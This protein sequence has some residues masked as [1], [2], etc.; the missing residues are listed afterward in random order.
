[1]T[2]NHVLGLKAVLP[3]A[4]LVTLG[5]RSLEPRRARP[6]RRLSSARKGC[7]ASRSRSRCGCCRGRR[8]TAPC[9][10]RTTRSKPPATRSRA[11][12]ASGL[13]PGAMEIMDHLAIQAAEAAVHAG[14]PLDAA[15]MLHRRARGRGRWKSRRS[16]S[17]CRALIRRVGRLPTCAS[18]R[19][20]RSA[21]AIWKGRK[22]AFSAVGRLSPDFIVQDGVVPRT[23][24]RR[25]AGRHRGVSAASTACASPT[26]ST[27]AT[28]T[29]T[30]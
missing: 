12:V 28:A 17:T 19:T 2:L 5:G 25:G 3:T 22:S 1:M 24:A 6:R 26:S 4:T 11:V 23:P 8:A 29:C 16:S 15:A 20:R 27:P 13:L 21:L 18:R 7:S 9:S 14:Y 10:P 30:R